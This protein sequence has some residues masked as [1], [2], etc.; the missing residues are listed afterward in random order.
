MSASALAPE[1]RLI[2]YISHVR[3]EVVT[4]LEAVARGLTAV[5]TSA[6]RAIVPTTTTAELWAGR[7]TSGYAVRCSGGQ[8]RTTPC[9]DDVLAVLESAIYDAIRAWHAEVSLLHAACVSGPACGTLVLAG[10][11]GAGKSSLAGAALA[12]GYRY[13][14]DE[15]TI[16]RDGAM[17][18]VPRALQYEA[19]PADAPLPP[20][21]ANA[22]R[23]AY[24]LRLAS[25]RVTALPLVAVAPERVVTQPLAAAEATLIA[26][27]RVP[28]PS[29]CVERLD[30]LSTLRV[31][32]EAQLTES[33]A[34]LV[35]AKRRAWRLRWHEPSAGLAQLEAQLAS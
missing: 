11:S 17:W 29:S 31:L 28:G 30:T 32:R 12:R 14:S 22:D 9:V 10:P 5:W 13:A 27:E 26:L 35:L 3:V 25:G 20:W 21:L 6:R 15:L 24:R 7:T 2:F 4:A 16:V 23:T 18:G 8:L 33:N 1:Q 19:T 34:A